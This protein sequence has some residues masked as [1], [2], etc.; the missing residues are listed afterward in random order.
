MQD[1]Q[2]AT[3]PRSVQ[4]LVRLGVFLSLGGCALAIGMARFHELASPIDSLDHELR[5][6]TSS[7]Q[8][9]QPYHAIDMLD[10]AMYRRHPRLI[11]RQNGQLTPLNLEPEDGLS[12]SQCAPSNEEAGSWQLAGRWTAYDR[13]QR[14]RA[15]GLARFEVPSGRIIDQV[16]L[17][18][19]TTGPLCWFPQAP[20]RL[21]IC[22]GENHLYRFDFEDDSHRLRPLRWRVKP[23]GIGPVDINDLCW[24][25]DPRFGNRVLMSVT[26]RQGS[27]GQVISLPSQIWWFQLDPGATEVKAIG[28]LTSS[29][30]P[31]P[32]KPQVFERWARLATSSTG[33]F[34][35]AYLIRAEDTNCWDL[36]IAPV[37][38]D[39]A[40]GIPTTRTEVNITLAHHLFPAT[41]FTSIDGRWLYAAF[42]DVDHVEVRR[43]LVGDALAAI[44]GGAR[45]VPAQA[46][47]R[48]PRSPMPRMS[49]ALRGSTAA[50]AWSG[51]ESDGTGSPRSFS[52]RIGFQEHRD[53]SFQVVGADALDQKP[54]LTRRGS[55]DQDDLSPPTPQDLRQQGG[56]RVVGLALFRRG[57]H[58]HA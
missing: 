9:P 4:T 3:M 46:S 17:D 29:D 49:P 14:A 26:Y 1:T 44:Q 2:G 11:D 7:S 30:A 31:A 58:R 55:R 5:A 48:S 23:P 37:S 18:I 38:I 50:A 34:Y 57:R 8:V 54:L 10:T 40:T 22:E 24:P 16:E 27:R 52:R 47:L 56:D 36:R 53:A 33:E 51:V 45:T 43:F 42:G 6:A 25:A 19:R 41:P 28:R 21:L 13:Q 32:G 39:R 20:A 35:V 15:V 12:N